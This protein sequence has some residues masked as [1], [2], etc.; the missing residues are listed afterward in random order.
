MLEVFVYGTLKPDGIYHP[1][2]CEGKVKASVPAIARGDLFHLTELGYPAMTEGENWVKGVLLTFADGSIL[3]DLDELEGYR[4]E[5]PPEENEYG[6]HKI[7]VYT[8]SGEPL[9]E[10]WVYRMTRARIASHGGIPVV[11]GWWAGS[12]GSGP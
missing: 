3:S 12:G 1:L 9:G 7:A 4:S 6:R 5:R 11:S 8:P 10:V 2:Y